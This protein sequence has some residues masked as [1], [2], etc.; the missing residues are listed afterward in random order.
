[1]PIYEFKCQS[2]GSAFETL[3]MGFSTDGVTCPKCKSE[4]VKKKISSFAVKGGNQRDTTFSA[5][6]CNT[7][8]T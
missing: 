7:G 2:C 8:S 3:I 5:A 4:Q 1:M 6:S